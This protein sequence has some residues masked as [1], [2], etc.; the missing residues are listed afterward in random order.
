MTA[1]SLR[2]V[3]RGQPPTQQPH[4]GLR[5]PGERGRGCH[6]WLGQQDYRFVDRQAT[7][8]DVDRGRLGQ[9]VGLGR[10]PEDE[11]ERASEQVEQDLGRVGIDLSGGVESC[12]HVPRVQGDL[13]QPHAQRP[14]DRQRRGQE[15]HL[16]MGGGEM[17]R[18]ELLDGLDQVR[19]VD[20]EP[21]GLLLGSRC[22]P[23]RPDRLVVDRRCGH[24]FPRC[25]QAADGDLGPTAEVGQH[26]ADSPLGRRARC[27]QLVRTQRSDKGGEL[28]VVVT[29]RGDG[30]VREVRGERSFGERSRATAVSGRP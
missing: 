27:P 9:L 5:R 12:A 3:R 7:T 28:V 22:V 16:D 29:Q 6:R 20:D 15:G 30:A 13:V 25:D 10:E 11:T 23:A 19:V 18:R 17:L 14:G 4:R 2:G 26:V 1:T 8:R 21:G 24:T